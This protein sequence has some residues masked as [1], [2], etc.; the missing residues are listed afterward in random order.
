MTAIDR[1][2]LGYT[3]RLSHGASIH[4]QAALLADTAAALDIERPILVGHSYGGAVSL[5]WAV[6]RPDDLSGLVLLGAASN[7]WETGLS[8]YYRVLSH[9]LGQRFFAP[10]L[11]AWVPER[12]VDDTIASVFTPQSE[13]DG[14]AP[15]I[16]AGLTLRRASLREN[17]LQRASILEEIEE[18]HTQYR[19]ISVPTEIL[20]GDADT[21]VWLT[22]HSEPLSRQING[23]NLVV[24]EGVGHMPH[25][26]QPQTAVDASDR[27]AERAG[28]R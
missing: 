6:D 1:P 10:I 21:T 24:M 19:T 25:H 8:F 18:L 28:L 14:Y 22:I 5:A 4:E 27:V 17:A 3:G 2:G 16:G 20:H 11:T 26:A 12:V 23:A 9:P 13:P 7:P 15:F